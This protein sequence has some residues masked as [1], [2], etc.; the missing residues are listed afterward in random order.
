MFLCLSYMTISLTTGK[1]VPG[2]AR[3]ME[4]DNKSEYNFLT[5]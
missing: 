2:A 4:K 3:E 5:I 1:M